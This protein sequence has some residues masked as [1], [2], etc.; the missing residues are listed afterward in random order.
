[1]TSGSFR[2]FVSPRS[3]E[4]LWSH[5]L[6]YNFHWATVSMVR[7]CHLH[8]VGN[9]KS[10]KTVDLL[11]DD[12]DLIAR[13][14][15]SERGGLRRYQIPYLRDPEAKV[16]VP[17]PDVH[18]PRTYH[19]LFVLPSAQTAGDH[20]VASITNREKNASLSNIWS[21]ST[22]TPQNAKSASSSYNQINKHMVR[23]NQGDT[24]KRFC[25]GP[26]SGPGSIESRPEQI[27]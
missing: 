8:Q 21:Y 12:R 1:M 9:L 23:A 15:V 6:C 25:R 13:V 18:L 4:G 20:P 10:A 2:H 7:P 27:S 16:S 11:Q 24:T 22:L 19:V 17:S 26:S 3:L 5:T 14:E